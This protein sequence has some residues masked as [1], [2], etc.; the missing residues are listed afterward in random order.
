MSNA[1]TSLVPVLDGT[2]YQE[3]AKAMEAYL[4]SMDLWEYANGDEKQ[5]TQSSPPTQDEKIAFKAW[6]STNQKALANIILQVKPS[7]REDIVMLNDAETIWNHLKTHFDMVQPTTLFKDFKAAISIQIDATKHPLP[8][9]NRLQAVVQCLSNN[10]V[11]M[12]KIIQA[13]ILLSALPPKWE[14]LISILC[15][16]YDLAHLQ[17]KHVREVIVAQWEAKRTKGKPQQSAQKLSA[18]K[19]KRGDL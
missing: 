10:G 3:W 7:I 6:K 18:V 8:Q 17:L 11:S 1:L 4:M 19:R 2:N 12:P 9:V 14:M 15:T 13:M 16:N 5:P